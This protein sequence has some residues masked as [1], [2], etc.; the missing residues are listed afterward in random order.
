[1]TFRSTYSRYA[2]PTS[3][4][5]PIGIGSQDKIVQLGRD[6]ANNR[7]K[8]WIDNAMIFDEA[9]TAE[10]SRSTPWPIR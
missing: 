9:L 5:E 8:G 1:M 7:W 3:S 6:H 2:S 10:Q 4:S